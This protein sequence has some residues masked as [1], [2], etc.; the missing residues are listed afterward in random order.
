MEPQSQHHSYLQTPQVIWLHPA[1]FS[2]RARHFRHFW[3]SLA[4]CYGHGYILEILVDVPDHLVA[5]LLWMG[6][7]IALCADYRIAFWALCRVFFVVCDVYYHRAFG[8]GAPFEIWVLLYGQV[9]TK[10]LILLKQCIA[11]ILLDNICANRLRTVRTLHI[12]NP[13]IKYLLL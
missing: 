7:T 5:R 1:I 3:I 10:C 13:E 11:N 4:Y 9:P 12:L 2:T 8:V 6:H